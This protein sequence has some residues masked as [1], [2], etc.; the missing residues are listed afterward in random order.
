M[1][2]MPPS[3]WKR[4]SF[5]LLLG[6]LFIEQAA[7]APGWWDRLWADD[8]EGV[9]QPHADESATHY[10]TDEQ[11][12]WMIMALSFRGPTATKD[13]TQTVAELRKKHKL[14]AYLHQETYDFSKSFVGRGV[15][16]FG[17]PRRMRH[18]SN[19]SF[20][21]VAVLIG[22]YTS[23]DDPKAQRDLKKI[24][25]LDLSS[26]ADEDK[27]ESRSFAELRKV[28]NQSLKKDKSSAGG[29]MKLAF[30]TTNPLLP[31]EYFRPQGVDRFVA[32]LN[33]DI[34]HSLL[35]CPETFTVKVAT[36]TGLAAVHPK[37][38]KE[39]ETKGMQSSR[40]EKGAIKAH[41]LTIA[42]RAKGYEAYQFHDR[43][44]SIVTVGSFSQAEQVNEEGRVAYTPEV[45][46]LLQR[47]SAKRQGT[48]S[49]IQHPG[50]QTGILPETLLGIPFDIKP[51][52]ISVP[53]RSVS[54]DFAQ[55][56][57]SNP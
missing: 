15:D 55:R 32:Q 33:E 30:I 31:E 1:L 51:V 14:T 46:E 57:L 22:N 49:D 7:A 11:G 39:I 4:I 40:L 35:D 3:I 20:E 8:P 2:D 41:R 19:N 12:P 23:V 26:L 34:E 10:L 25:K 42:L 52:L 37:H 24:K 9:K 5:L 27:K 45:Q 43:K 47:F 38:I 50:L 18:Q 48:S 21:E 28:H 13:A 17:N 53:Q 16:R 54:S 6:T 44:Q 36:F 56:T 29:A